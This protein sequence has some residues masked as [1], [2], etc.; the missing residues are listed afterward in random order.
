MRDMAR[1]EK[2]LVTIG[3]LVVWFGLAVL[4]LR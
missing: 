3:A 2:V 1:I 4:I